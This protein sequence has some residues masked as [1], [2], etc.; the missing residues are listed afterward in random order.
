MR[1]LPGVGVCGRRQGL[2]YAND[3]LLGKIFL[4]LTEKICYTEKNLRNLLTVKIRDLGET[5]PF[6]NPGDAPVLA[7]QA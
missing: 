1:A 2:G 6:Q 5:T 4:K 3:T 7:W